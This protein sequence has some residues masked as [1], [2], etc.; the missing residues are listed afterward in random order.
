ERAANAWTQAAKDWKAYGDDSIL[1]SYDFRIRLNDQERFQQD[2]DRYR[3]Q[4]ESL[5]QGLRDKIYAERYATLSAEEQ[6]LAELNA[7]DVPED[8][9]DTYFSVR[10][11]LEITP[12]HLAE[13]IEKEHPDLA[14]EA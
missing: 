7:Q 12:V 11:K 4:L 2:A 8:Q 5:E 14:L 9:H 1:T 10:A 3:K 13:R 6:R